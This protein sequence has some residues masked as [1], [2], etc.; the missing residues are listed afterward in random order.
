MCPPADTENE[1]EMVPLRKY[2][3]VFLALVLALSLSGCSGSK[4]EAASSEEEALVHFL[5]DLQSGNF[6]MALTYLRPGNQL[7][8]VLPAGT[9]EAAV[10]EMDEVYRAFLE[11]LKD[12]TFR[13]TVDNTTSQYVEFLEVHAQTRD[14]D[15]A[16]RA[17]MAEALRLQCEEGSS[18]FAD[19]TG[20]MRQAIAGAAPGEAGDAH[21][22]MVGKSG[23]YTLDHRGYPDVAFLNLITGGFYE[24]IDCSMTTCTMRRGGAR[25]TYYLAA[26]GDEVVG[27]LTEIEESYRPEDFS[28]EDKAVI[29]AYYAEQAAALDGVYSG[30]RFGEDKVTTVTGIDFNEASQTAMINTGIVSGKYSGNT[31]N[32]YLSLR[33]TIKGFE[34]EGMTCTTVPVYEADD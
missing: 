5:T 25:Y 22:T 18:A 34:E 13:V 2:L 1:K 11:G 33:A 17:A 3:S 23:D 19:M 24:Y 10:P 6:E 9:E 8:R 28:E 21:A 32:N 12:M 29:Q 27:Y 20:W 14:Y 4:Q 26:R 30:V 16:I 31:T 15:S 7:R